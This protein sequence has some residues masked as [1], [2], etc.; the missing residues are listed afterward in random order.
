[1]KQRLVVSVLLLGLCGVVSASGVRRATAPVPPT[2]EIEILDP[3]VDPTGKPTPVV[4][5]GPG[6]VQLVDIPPTV[7]VHRYYYSGDRSFQAQLLPGGPTIV[8]AS[9][10]RTLE[11]VY[12]PVTLPPGAP[13][14]SYTPSTIRYDFGPQSVT[15]VF[16]LCGDPK[17]HYSQATALGNRMTTAT[18]SAIARA[19]E[20]VERTGL[21]EGAQ[22]L[23]EHTRET[24]GSAADRVNDLGRAVVT[25]ISKAAGGVFAGFKTTAEDRAIR[26][27]DRLQRM[28]EKGANT[29]NTF[30]PRGP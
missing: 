15:L 13:R 1:M 30:V 22:K 23:A 21:P 7:L 17:V 25:P 16:G 28:A 2:Q 20:L 26:E 5:P 14:V 27:Q 3:N 12:V 24:M 9:H 18:A 6:G 10:P 11:R 19:K 8:V 4:R 29:V